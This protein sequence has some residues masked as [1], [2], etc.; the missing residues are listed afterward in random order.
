MFGIG[1]P[2]LIV[3]LGVALIVVGPERLPELAKSIA[4]GLMELKRAAMTLKENID[5]E[6][7]DIDIDQDPWR[8]R[9]DD[10]P[11]PLAAAT[12]LPP[13]THPERVVPQAEQD[14]DGDTPRESEP[15]A[16]LPPDGEGSDSTS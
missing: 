8:Q 15:Q 7:K 3:I 11:P 5:E 9:L 10:R 4:K 16:A 14:E 12:D 13:P 2:E 6:L 1:L